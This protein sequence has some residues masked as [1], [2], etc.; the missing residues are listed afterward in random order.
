MEWKKYTNGRIIAQH[1]AGFYCIKPEN[2]KKGRPLFCP[3]C[4]K[5]MGTSFD[6]DAY[7]KFECCDSCA[8][9]WA[10]P[11]KDMWMKGWRPTAE[12]VMN[13]YKIDHT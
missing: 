9:K 3:I 2:H 8:S 10:Y 6:E 1:P 13:K 7:D 12:E 4:E 11:N 5:V